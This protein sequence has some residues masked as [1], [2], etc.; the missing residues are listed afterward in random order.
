VIVLLVHEGAATVDIA[1]AT[2][3]SPFGRIV[4]GANANVDA[5]VSGHTHLAYDHEIPVPGT[6]RVRPVISSGQYGEK[7]SHTS[8]SIDPK[9][10]DLVSISA[11][12]LP[13]AGAFTPDPEVATIVAD[14]VAVAKVLGAVKVG[15]ITAAINRAKQTAP[16]S[17]NRGGE[18]TLGN[19]V[20]DVQLWSTAGLGSQIAF[21]NPGGLR[22]DLKYPS[23]GSGD[24]DGNV[25]FAEAAGVQPFANTLITMDLTGEQIRQA[26]SQQAQ[27]LASSRPFL[28]L[29]VSE[30][31]EYTATYVPPVA[32]ADPKPAQYLVGEMYL[33]GEPIDLTATYTVTVNS[34]LA[35]GGDNFGAFATGSDKADSGKVDLQSMVDYFEANPVAS[36]DYAQRAIGVQFS[37][38][39]ADG[40]APGDQVTLALSSLLFSN[41]EP[42]A[43][44][45]VVSAGETELGSAVIDPAIVDTTDEV[46]RASVTITI[47]EGTPGGTLL[48]TVS[49]PETGTSIDVPLEVVSSAEPIESVTAPVITGQAR[50]G[51]TISTTGGTWS[52][53]DPTLAYQ[54]N[55]EGVPIEG[56]T[57]ASYRLVGADA[58]A[59]ITVTVTASRDGYTNGVATSS[60]FEVRK[61]SSST[62]A[63]ATRV[64]VFGNQPVTYSV[65]VRGESGVIPTGEVAIYDGSRKLTTVTIDAQ[66]RA[67]VPIAGLGRGLHILTARYLG[68]DQVTPSISWPSILY[69]F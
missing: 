64:I 31:F 3:D 48:L 8:I 29:G 16:G 11:E 1:S 33:D 14:A 6:D 10:G 5:I 23:S 2:D 34:F 60:E 56:A 43:G 63:S 12:V 24:P 67:T 42:N 30:G 58:G 47:P 28:R 22:A 65:Q 55:R 32:G 19:F 52:V 51:R 49:V 4:T 9:T 53:D 61:V 46:G 44:T 15:D 40:Y 27:P 45:A 37:A 18:S 59:S 7:F 50:V 68:D 35:A 20:A 39:D 13:L 69:R 62:T 38:P 66:G 54:W 36:P 25:T 41:G 26:L 21:M 17:E 57:A